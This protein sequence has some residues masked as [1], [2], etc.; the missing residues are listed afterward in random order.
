MACLCAGGFGEQVKGMRK[1]GKD[2]FKVLACAFRAAGQLD[3]QRAPANA[4]P[5]AG[6]LWCHVARGEAR[7]ACGQDQVNAQVVSPACQLTCDCLT[8]IGDGGANFH[9]PPQPL[10]D[11]LNDKRTGAMLIRSRV[12]AVSDGQDAYPPDPSVLII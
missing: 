12:D 1:G 10:L 7:A 8:L 2:H 5:R 9:E 3:D 6:G 4:A 11:Y